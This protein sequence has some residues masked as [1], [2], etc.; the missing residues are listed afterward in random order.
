VISADEAMF[1]GNTTNYGFHKSS[2][3]ADI[4]QFINLMRLP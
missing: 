3:I 1:Y 4:E 2:F